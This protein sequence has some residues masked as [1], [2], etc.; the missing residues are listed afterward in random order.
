[1][2]LVCSVCGKNTLKEVKGEVIFNGKVRKNCSSIFCN[3]GNWE[4]VKYLDQSKQEHVQN[5]GLEMRELLD[6]ITMKDRTIATHEQDLANLTAQLDQ[7]TKEL[8]RA[9]QELR[10]YQN[11]MGQPTNPPKQQR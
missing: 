7:K 4:Q 2:T 11:E 6:K 9:N 10:K 8:E 3:C 1:M 5:P